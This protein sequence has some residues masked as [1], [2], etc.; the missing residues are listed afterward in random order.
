M[1]EFQAS[2]VIGSG[3]LSFEMIR[4]LTERLP[5]MIA[6]RGAGTQAEFAKWKINGILKLRARDTAKV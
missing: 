3:S 5:V 1:I 6:P 2:I 4:A